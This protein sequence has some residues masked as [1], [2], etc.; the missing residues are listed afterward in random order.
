MDT[1]QHWDKTIRHWHEIQICYWKDLIALVKFFSEK[2]VKV[3]YFG[4]FFLATISFCYCMNQGFQ[5]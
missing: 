3:K 1:W 2:Y 5:M 4:Y